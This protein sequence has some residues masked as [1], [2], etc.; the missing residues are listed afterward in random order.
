MSEE[1]VKE[2][3]VKEPKKKKSKG[4]TELPEGWSNPITAKKATEKELLRGR[5]KKAMLL[6]LAFVLIVTSIVYIMLLQIN[7]NNIR[8]TAY[9]EV[10]GHKLSLSF[11]MSDWDN[12]LECDGPS[13]MWDLSYNPSYNRE[14]IY[15]M[16]E[17][18]RML[19]DEQ[20]SIGQLSGESYLSGMLVVRNNNSGTEYLKYSMGLEYN[21]K[22]LNE[23]I[24]VL[25]GSAIRKDDNL[26][27]GEEVEEKTYTDLEA[28]NLKTAYKV[29]TNVYANRS[30]NS[31][32]EG[33]SINSDST[34][35]TGYIEYIAYPIGSQYESFSLLEYETDLATPDAYKSS[36]EKTK[37]AEG[38]GYKE[39][40]PFYD[41]QHVLLDCAKLEEGEYM[42]VY[43][44]IWFEG[45]DFECVDAVLGGYVKLNVDFTVI[46]NE[47][48]DSLNAS[49]HPEP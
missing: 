46:S 2:E 20:P 11:N 5:I 42:F 41:D 13:K 14:H 21:K 15:T 24:R 45:S 27:Y 17:V 39:T 28:N 16:D 40:I 9:S 19:I 35:E 4:K 37:E 48:Y 1:E 33:T 26:K 25:W 3:K 34:E 29:S 32:L 6:I 43:F 38:L 36:Y 8:I 7:E 30:K 47:S 31:R 44:N 23:A 10:D 12:V 18:E 49:L 22:G